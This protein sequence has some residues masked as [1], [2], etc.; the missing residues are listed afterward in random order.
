MANNLPP[1]SM[2]T[3]PAGHDSRGVACRIACIGECMVEL[4]ASGNNQFASAFAGDTLNTAVYLARAKQHSVFFV[5]V[6][7]Q[8]A[9][10][11][12]MLSA[13][14]DNG[15]D[16]SL[17]TRHDSRLPGLYMIEND[18]R[19]E[20]SFLY[21]RNQ[22]AARTLFQ[23]ESGL[24]VKDLER[25]DAVYLSGITLAIMDP[26]AR[27]TLIDYLSSFKA[28]GGQVAFDSN[29]RPALWE[30]QQVACDTVAKMWSVATHGFPSVDDEMALF[31]DTSESAAVQRL[32][33]YQVPELVLKRGDLGPRVFLHD[34][35]QPLPA[36]PSAQQVVDT[37]GAGDS[38][39]AGYLNARLAGSDS[40]SA[41]QQAHALALKVIAHA[42]AIL[43]H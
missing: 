39:N 33:T 12:Q 10:S 20:R 8:D 40:T 38:F 17:V 14:R 2:Q 43:P 42:G 13:W 32:L 1:D 34:D 19:G 24:S 35:E 9:V 41:A 25:V 15:I 28:N 31:G 16:T 6:V 21:W 30:S 29:Y 18:S 26:Q 11:D 7:G 22:S 36:P 5:S 4:R 3:S 23:P 37:T 27:N